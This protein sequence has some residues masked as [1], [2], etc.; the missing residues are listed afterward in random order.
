V[1]FLFSRKLF[2]IPCLLLSTAASSQ[3][4][5]NG[6]AKQNSCN[7]Y[8]LTEPQPTQ[9]GSVW[10]SNKISLTNSFDYWFN[11]YLGCLDGN[12]AD[13]IVFML[14]PLSTSVGTSGE[15]MG[16]SGVMPSIGIALDTWQNFNQNDPSYDHISIQ[17]NG[18]VNH[19]N[20]LVP[21]V[22]ISSTNDNVEDCKWH[23]LRITWDAASNWLRAYFDG[24]LRVEKQIDLI[25]TIFRNDPSVYW[26]FTGATGGSVN[27]QQFCTALNPDFNTNF[28]NNAGCDGMAIQFKNQSESF[29]P[30]ATY[31]WNFGDGATASSESP[32]PHL[33]AKPGDY[34]VNLKI[35][36]IDGCENDTTKVV[37]IGSIPNA[38]VQISDTC[39][40]NNPRVA[41]KTNNFGVS[42]HW[43][44]DGS[45]VSGGNVPD[46]QTLKAGPH[47]VQLIVESLY[48]CGNPDTAT[49]LF[50]IKPIP[51]IAASKSQ[52]CDIVNFSA[53]QLD[54]LTNIIDWK[55]KFGDNQQSSL[56]NP[57]HTYKKSELYTATVQAMADNGCYSTQLSLPVDI[58]YAYAFAGNDT[59][60]IRNLPFQL[61][62]SGN[63][64]FQWSPS[65]LVSDANISNP[66]ITLSDNQD[67]VLKVTTDEGCVVRDTI[68]IK[69]IE[70]PTVYVPTAF[71][72]N[73]DGRNDILQPIY[74]GIINID[75]FIVYSRW[76]ETVF[77]T[78]DMKKGWDGKVRSS[79]QPTGTYV[80]M[81]KAQNYLKQNIILKGTVTLIR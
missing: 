44:V 29:A 19:M 79:V 45:S 18:Q 56:Q 17:A 70:G 67:F 11:V 46:L 14:Q 33:Y 78:S 42:Y 24:V 71:T 2:L 23:R 48:Q 7:C 74:V 10:N 15:G 61:N 69:A 75:Q 41:F 36:G 47:N 52:A 53:N 8:T 28:Q 6:S 37:T 81:V 51:E 43:I 55:W 77:S 39:Y 20:D 12:G 63:G 34:S 32:A 73:G 40:L 30:I 31:N 64:H 50:T 4:I 9:S 66:E 72:P 21:P 25:G 22:P 35:K 65:S 27:L 60:I 49:A 57:V 58:P 5:L 76:G 3:Y 26:G 80:W 59:T 54:Q 13:G 16:F 68:R 62:G 1:N 38:E